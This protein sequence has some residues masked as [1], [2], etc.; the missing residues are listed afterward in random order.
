M[1]PRRL[2]TCP[3]GNWQLVLEIVRELNKKIYIGNLSYETTEEQVRELLEQHGDVESIAWITDLAVERSYR[4]QGIASALVL[5]AQNWALSKG[6]RRGIIEMPS[7]NF[8]AIN[9]ALKLGYEF[10]GY[11]DQYYASQDVTLFFG[12]ALK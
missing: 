10:C 1:L 9:L 11:N 3:E 6:L 7:K 5:G 4:R 8:P 12:R 2:R